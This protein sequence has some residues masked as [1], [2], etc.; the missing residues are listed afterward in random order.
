MGAVEETHGQQ[1]LDQWRGVFLGNRTHPLR[2]FAL[3]PS[4]R[5]TQLAASNGILLGAVNIF[6]APNVWDVNALQDIDDQARLVDLGVI[7]HRTLN[8]ACEKLALCCACGLGGGGD[9][10]RNQ[11]VKLLVGLQTLG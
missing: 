9:S 1:L 4:G 11:N 3:G 7:E 5:W 10:A 6:K 8:D 2:Q